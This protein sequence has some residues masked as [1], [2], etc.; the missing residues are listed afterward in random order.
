MPEAGHPPQAQNA[1]TPRRRRSGFRRHRTYCRSLKSCCQSVV[2]R[3][4][5]LDQIEQP[6]AQ[7]PAIAARDG[8]AMADE[9]IRT[10]RVRIHSRSSARQR[11]RRNHPRRHARVNPEHGYLVPQCTA[12][13][14]WAPVKRSHLGKSPE[15]A[16]RPAPAA[17]RTR[18]ARR[19]QHDR[20]RFRPRR[21]TFS[22]A[23]SGQR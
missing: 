14:S 2:V 20:R 16:L 11:L 10:G 15:A 22:G 21:T 9:M 6:A 8:Y 13:A 17:P 3:L 18:N 7:R 12:N 5:P 19:V 23:L 1:A 4:R